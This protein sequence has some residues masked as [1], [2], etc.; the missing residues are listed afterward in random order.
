MLERDRAQGG[1]LR[2]DT[3]MAASQAV[4]RGRAALER[5]VWSEAYAQLAAADQEAPLEPDDLDRLA[6]VPHPHEKRRQ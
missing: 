5:G 6:T 2:D 4:A 3:T 1:C